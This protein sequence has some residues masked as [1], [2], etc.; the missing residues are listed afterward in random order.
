MGEQPQLSGSRVG[1]CG[2]DAAA[3][4][5]ATPLLLLAVVVCALLLSACGKQPLAREEAEYPESL[6]VPPDLLGEQEAAER[7]RRERDAA[8]REAGEEAELPVAVEETVP[9]RLQHVDGRPELHLA[10]SLNQAWREI[11]TA[12]D[13]LDFTLL[14]RQRDE[15]RY[16]IRYA[17]RADEEVEQPGWFAR[18]FRGAER[19][20][21]A[22][23]RYRIELTQEPRAVVVQVRDEAG[24]AASPAI[25]ER[26]LTLLDRQLPY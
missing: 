8:E 15:L 18:L 3:G 12:L 17:P 13:R 25:A 2:R 26:L 9:S 7:S 22:P 6:L 16:E 5:L 14:G 4:R 11:G 10:T 20:E 24:E 19:I 21:T 1:C 23:Q